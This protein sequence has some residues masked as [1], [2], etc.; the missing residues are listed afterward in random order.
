MFIGHFALGFAAKKAAPKLPLGALFIGAQLLD[1][2]WPIF[3]LTGLETVRVS[4]G[5]TEVTPLE[6]VSYPLSHGLVPV[7]GWAVLLGL[8]ILAARGYPRG[9][10]V[11][12]AL[13]VSHWVLDWITHRP[14]LPIWPSWE[15]K[16]GLGLWHSRPATLIVE[17]L[18]YVIGVAIYAGMTEATSRAGRW[19]LWLL[20]GFLAAIYVGNLYS[21]P[22]PSAKAVAWSALAMWL[23]I[24]WGYWLDGR[25]TVRQ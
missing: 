25:R 16:F 10:W 22:P 14:D 6:F 9:A 12:A 21:P 18:M 15:A 19:G 2:I 4:P 8:A 20:V 24:I 1:L 3:V 5:D 13:V 23:I 7:L 11:V 17:G